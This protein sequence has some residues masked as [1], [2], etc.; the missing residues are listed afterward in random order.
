ME[1]QYTGSYKF[2]KH[3]CKIIHS[4]LLTGGMASYPSSFYFPATNG[5]NALLVPSFLFSLLGG[6]S[7][8]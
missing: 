3:E 2:V 5:Q 7:E 1:L 6:R 4:Y 8:A